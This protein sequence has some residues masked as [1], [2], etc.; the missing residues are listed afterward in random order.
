M[1]KHL[2]TVV[3][4]WLAGL[5]DID[6]NVTRATQESLAQ[7]FPSDEKRKNL[8]RLYRSSIIAFCRDSITKETVHTLSDE[9]TTSPDDAFAKHA[10]VVGASALVVTNLLENYSP[11]TVDEHDDA[12]DEFLKES[13]VWDL[14]SHS[15]AFVRRAVYRLLV[16]SLHRMKGSLD[17]KIISVRLL[18]SSLHT[19]QTGSALDYATALSLLTECCPEVWTRYYS[20]SGKK[21]AMRRLQQ[22]LKKGSQ[23]GPPD[24]WDRIGS[25]IHNIPREVFT[26]QPDDGAS[27]K[28][29]PVAAQP[30]LA[31]L[32]AML[33]ALRSKDE[34]S[35]NLGIA[36]TTYLKVFER[37][38]LLANENHRSQ[39]FKDFVLPIVPQYVKPSQEGPAWL[40]AK[41]HTYQ[42]SICARAFLLVWSEEE[43]ILHDRWTALSQEI[44]Q[45]IKISRPEQSRDYVKSQSSL[46]EETSRWFDLE[47]RIMKEDNS[48]SIKALFKDTSSSV[49]KAAIES[50]RSRNGKPSGATA[51]LVIAFQF[52]PELIHGNAEL[53]SMIVQFVQKDCPNLL[54]SPSAPYIFTLLDLS[55]GMLDISRPYQA[56]LQILKETPNSPEKSR[57]LTSLLSSPFLAKASGIDSL[58]LLLGDTLTSALDGDEGNWDLVQAAICN[59]QAPTGMIDSLLETM[60]ES[61]EIEEK[62][63]GGL[64]GLSITEKVK[65]DALKTFSTSP[66]GTKLLSR[67]LTL[68]ESR[69][70]GVSGKAKSL[71]TTIKGFMSGEEGSNM[72][73]EPIIGIIKQGLA[74]P[75]ASSLP[76]VTSQFFVI[77]LC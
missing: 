37:M 56:G 54:L 24:L 18:A 31:I 39:L 29:A 45:D 62:I 51:T 64:K 23:G 26:A 13:K 11:E 67:L 60:A 72:A 2:P 69:D 38:M 58:Q 25:I 76:W 77:P 44:V 55:H 1:A 20:G 43:E 42:L 7:V 4:P 65:G 8:W 70:E 68:A 63:L 16:A 46:L 50:I 15:D 27:E 9:R 73:T 53:K 41:G 14:A 22:F 48:E 12:F 10:R 61:L 49:L 57:A 47:E 3:G 21:T 66:S 74:T 28:E 36:W 35:R 71:S 40:P 34:P 19:D 33:F 52:T 5:Y 59:P 75:T 32:E 30:Q 6:K 17:M